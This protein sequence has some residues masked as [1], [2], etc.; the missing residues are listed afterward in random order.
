M[1]FQKRDAETAAR[2]LAAYALGASFLFLLISVSDSE[3]E[4]I[5]GM[6]AIILWIALIVLLVIARIVA[7]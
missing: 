2:V 3:F 4:T 5:A 1:K 6:T 7:K